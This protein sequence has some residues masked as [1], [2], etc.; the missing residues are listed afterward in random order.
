MLLIWRNA[1][2]QVDCLKMCQSGRHAASYWHGPPIRAHVVSLRD[3]NPYQSFK[4]IWLVGL[5]GVRRAKQDKLSIRGEDWSIEDVESLR[6]GQFHPLGMTPIRICHE[7][8]VSRGFRI[9]E[10]VYKFG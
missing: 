4:E 10:D 3:L 5:A 7:Q 6:T 1:G 8:F 2:E 9:N